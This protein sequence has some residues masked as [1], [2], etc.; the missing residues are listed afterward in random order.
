M[1]VVGVA[2]NVD[3]NNF[4]PNQENSIAHQNETNKAYEAKVFQT[5]IINVLEEFAIKVI[6]AGGEES[7]YLKSIRHA[8]VHAV[9]RCAVWLME[10]RK[11]L[12][13]NDSFSCTLRL[14]KKW[15]QSVA[16]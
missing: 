13:K 11:Q 4:K 10:Q 2:I 15:E 14:Y 9:D 3:G 12:T 1:E 8:F 16:R 6:S 5:E 7:E